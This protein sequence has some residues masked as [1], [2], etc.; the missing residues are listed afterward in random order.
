MELPDSA[1]KG[2]S[3]AIAI[4]EFESHY[5]C[6]CVFRNAKETEKT[7]CCS[8]K[9]EEKVSERTFLPYRQGV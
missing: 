6:N 8:H 3:L 7:P 2:G 4:V 5:K 9:L 1:C